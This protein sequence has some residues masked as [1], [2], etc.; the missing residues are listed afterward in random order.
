MKQFTDIHYTILGLLS[1]CGW[2]SL[3]LLELLDY[4]YT[5]R[6]RA[7]KTLLDGQFIRKSGKGRAK[8]YA[9]ST[10]GRNLLAAYNPQRFGGGTKGMAKQLA[11]H[12]ERSV[13]RGDAAAF[14]SFGGFSA[15]PNDKPALPAYTPILLDGPEG[16]DWRGLYRNTESHSYPNQPDQGVYRRRLTAVNCYYDATAV[17]ELAVDSAGVSYSRACGVLLTP[18]YLLRVY[19]SRDV[20]MKFHSTG[21]HNF[22][23]LLLS[24]KIFTGYLPEEQNAALVLGTDFTAAQH[25]LEH[26][27]AGHSSRMPLSAKKKG[28]KGYTT[29][30]GLAGELVTPTNLGKPAFYL[31]LCKDSL[32]LL[33]LMAY[34]FWQGFLVREICRGL[35][36]QLDLSHWCIEQDGYTVYILATLNLAQIDLAMRMVQGNSG[37]KVRIVCLDWQIPLFRQLLEPFAE[38][39]DLWLTKLPAGFLEG[40][41]QG[42]KEYWEGADEGSL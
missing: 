17:K 18:S 2:V 4:G 30:K 23:C 39:R 37:K 10:K 20:A 25:I 15:H 9:I 22:Q 42:E 1:T 12:P 11:R 28:G 27:L 32:P 31:P 21:E 5:Y 26:H 24:P 7:L 6:T 14:L 33:R 38:Q 19:H 36:P 29:V 40:L 35:F 34:P 41:L 16:A 8:A 13:Q 3:P